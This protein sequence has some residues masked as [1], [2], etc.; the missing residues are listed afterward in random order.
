[1]ESHLSAAAET[2]RTLPMA[3]AWFGIVAI[4]TFAVLLAVTFA[5]RSIGKK[6]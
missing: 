3:P 4:I 1:M 2:A 6:H 5:F